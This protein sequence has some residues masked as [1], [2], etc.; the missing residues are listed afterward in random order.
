MA[1]IDRVGVT[2]GTPRRYLENGAMRLWDNTFTAR[3]SPPPTTGP[4]TARSDRDMA[5]VAGPT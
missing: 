4:T 5:P 2:W 3:H 1:C